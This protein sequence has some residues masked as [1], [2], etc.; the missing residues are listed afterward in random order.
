MSLKYIQRVLWRGDGGYNGGGRMGQLRGRVTP[1]RCIVVLTHGKLDSHTK[2]SKRA[3]CC[4]FAF[5]SCLLFKFF[6][7]FF[8]FVACFLVFCL[9]VVVVVVVVVVLL[10]FCR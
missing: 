1:S 5:V 8:V 6:L 3:I 4:H 2:I 10:F 9:V 7:L